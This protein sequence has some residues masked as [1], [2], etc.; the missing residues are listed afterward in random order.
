MEFTGKTILITGAG[1]ALGRATARLLAERGADLVL[2][3]R[4]ATALATTGSRCA[5]SVTHCCDVTI[6]SEVED[7]ACFAQSAFDRPVY[8]LVGAAGM[9]GPVTPLIDISEEDYDRTFGLNTRALWLLARAVIPQMQKAGKGSVVLLSS[10]AG[11][12]ASQRLNLY[13]V[14]KAAVIMLARNFALNHAAENIRVNCV[15]PGTIEGPMTDTSIALPD[16]DDAARDARRQAVIGAHPMGR[17]GTPDE[18]AQSVAFLL[19]DAAGFTTG[20]ALPVDGGRLA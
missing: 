14:T 6:A 3:D 13:S 17:M 8:G 15:C 18:V 5:G 10:T 20:I 11:L 4:D 1:G 19:S 9:L 12:E 2:A 7:L 16:L